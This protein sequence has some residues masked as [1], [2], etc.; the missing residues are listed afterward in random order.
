MELTPNAVEILC[1]VRQSCV[2]SLL[3]Q[4]LSISPLPPRSATPLQ[5]RLT[6]SDGLQKFPEVGISKKALVLAGTVKPKCIIEILKYHRSVFKQTL[7]IDRIRVVDALSTIIGNPTLHPDSSASIK[8]I[9][10]SEN[11]RSLV[12]EFSH[13]KKVKGRRFQPSL[14]EVDLVE[15]LENTSSLGIAGMSV[16]EWLEG[17]SIPRNDQCSSQEPCRQGDCS[18]SSPCIFNQTLFHKCSKEEY[19]DQK[20]RA[21]EAFKLMQRHGLTR[22]VLLDGHGR[23]LFAILQQFQEEG[24]PFPSVVVVDTDEITHRFHCAFFPWEC[25]KS[26]HGDALETMHQLISNEEAADTLIYLNFC[27]IPANVIDRRQLAVVV[28]TFCKEEGAVMVSYTLGLAGTSRLCAS[29]PKKP[30]PSC[31]KFLLLELAYCF[32]RLSAVCLVR[33]GTWPFLTWVISPGSAWN[34]P[35]L[36]NLINIPRLKRSTSQ[37]L[38]EYLASPPKWPDDYDFTRF[39]GA[40]YYGTTLASAIAYGNAKHYSIMVNMAKAAGMRNPNLYREKAAI[41]MLS[42]GTDPLAIYLDPFKNPT[43]RTFKLNAA[44]SRLSAPTQRTRLSCRP[45][46]RPPQRDRCLSVEWMETTLSDAEAAMA[47]IHEQQ[48]SPT[49][50]S[51]TTPSFELL[52]KLSQYIEIYHGDRTSS[53]EDVEIQKTVL[54]RVL[55]ALCGWYLQHSQPPAPRRSQQQLEP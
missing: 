42:D 39:L 3:V 19:E 53:G 15:Q 33:P 6:L 25:V 4:V 9:P 55:Q 35:R 28:E 31:I 46:P 52:R 41:A 18:L 16:S 24:K 36:D 51:L 37:E 48:E 40:P 17:C 29:P 43:S 1:D 47:R 34:E 20:R 21:K 30:V 26:E 22:L 5:Y 7:I 45:A 38:P 13:L 49:H 10:T 11:L 23:M 54:R 32:S 14:Q 8:S 12:A 50:P 2:N 27:S 44:F